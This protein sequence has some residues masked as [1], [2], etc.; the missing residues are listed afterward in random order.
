[1]ARCDSAVTSDTWAG[2]RRHIYI[3][4]SRAESKLLRGRLV[5]RPDMLIRPIMPGPLSRRLPRQ[6]VRYC[7]AGVLLPPHLRGRCL[8]TAPLARHCFTLAAR[9]AARVHEGISRLG[10]RRPGISSDFLTVARDQLSRPFFC[11]FDG[12]SD[13]SDAYDKIENIFYA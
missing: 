2:T 7:G 5:M 8:L 3:G 10:L 1:M 12:R 9:Q 13:L 4:S 6:C 11:Y